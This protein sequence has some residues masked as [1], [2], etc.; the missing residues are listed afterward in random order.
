M[1]LLDG[2]Q[3]TRSCS[4][5]ALSGKNEHRSESIETRQELKSLYEQ[6]IDSCVQLETT[7]GRTSVV[8]QTFPEL[9]KSNRV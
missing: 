2:T 1:W 7:R 4:K 6:T 8:E 5:T 9:R 3:Q